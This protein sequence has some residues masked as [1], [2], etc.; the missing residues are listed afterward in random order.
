MGRVEIDLDATEGESDVGT[1]RKGVEF[2]EHEEEESDVE[3]TATEDGGQFEW[4]GICRASGTHMLS[5]A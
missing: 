3:I 5:L 4:Y 2:G 1:V